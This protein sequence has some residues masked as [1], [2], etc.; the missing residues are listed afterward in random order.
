MW[1]GI[2]VLTFYGFWKAPTSALCRFINQ[3][4]IARRFMWNKVTRQSVLWM[5]HHKSYPGGTIMVCI[6]IDVTIDKHREWRLIL[7][8]YLSHYSRLYCLLFEWFWEPYKL[9]PFLNKSKRII[10]DPFVVSDAQPTSI[11][12][13]SCKGSGS[14][15]VYSTARGDRDVFNVAVLDVRQYVM[16]PDL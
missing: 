12:T 6:G 3:L 2:T 4:D 16:T 5:Q 7:Q 13:G 15:E 1:V 9:V 10:I 11:S 8:G 14:T